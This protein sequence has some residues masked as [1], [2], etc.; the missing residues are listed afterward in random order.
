LPTEVQEAF[1][2]WRIWRARDAVALSVR[3]RLLDVSP[4]SLPIIQMYL[5]RLEEAD[6]EKT[7]FEEIYALIG[8]VDVYRQQLALHSEYLVLIM[9]AHLNPWGLLEFQRDFE[10]PADSTILAAR[11]LWRLVRE[12]K[13]DVKALLAQLP[14]NEVLAALEMFYASENVDS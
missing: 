2:H 7:I 5:E 13:V 11:E 3:R 9:S 8:V 4:D 6:T 10:R 12:W 1:D 14:R